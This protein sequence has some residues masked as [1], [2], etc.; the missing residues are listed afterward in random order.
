MISAK[1]LPVSRSPLPVN[2]NPDEKEM[3]KG[4]LT[5]FVSGL[6]PLYYSLRSSAVRSPT[7]EEIR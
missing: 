7:A 4:A 5:Q 6:P 2:L 1:S 3:R